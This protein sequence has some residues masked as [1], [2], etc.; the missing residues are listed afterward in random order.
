MV[1]PFQGRTEGSR[2]TVTTLDPLKDG[3]E[4]L[5]DDA[6]VGIEGLLKPDN[7]GDYEQFLIGNYSHDIDKLID[8]LSATQDLRTIAFVIELERRRLDDCSFKDMDERKS[9]L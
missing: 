7:L 3:V 8:Q 1:A 9:H 4:Q 6:S 2:S 5:C